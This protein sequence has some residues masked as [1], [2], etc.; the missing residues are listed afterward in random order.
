MKQSYGE[1]Q[2]KEDCWFLVPH[3][4]E[5]QPHYWPCILRHHNIL[6]VSPFLKLVQIGFL[7][8]ASKKALTD[9]LCLF[10]GTKFLRKTSL[11]S[12]FYSLLAIQSLTWYN[13]TS[14]LT[15][16][17]P[18]PVPYFPS[19]FCLIFHSILHC[20]PALLWYSLCDSRTLLVFPDSPFKNK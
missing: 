10:F 7:S 2:E 5:T 6:I 18:H 12:L 9:V 17:L 16:L 19:L 8:L 3:V 4:F 13:L 1:E 20:L 15:I 14:T 11:Y